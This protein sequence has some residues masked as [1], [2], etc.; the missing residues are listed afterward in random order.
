LAILL[1]TKSFVVYC[2]QA[3]LIFRYQ[4]SCFLNSA[5][6]IIQICEQIILI[7]YSARSIWD[8]YMES[9]WFCYISISMQV[10]NRYKP[11]IHRP[12]YSHLSYYS[13]LWK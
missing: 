13:K 3:P 12:E 4:Q 6:L 1:Y 11:H 9:R 7:K 5:A 2:L 10:Q 8:W